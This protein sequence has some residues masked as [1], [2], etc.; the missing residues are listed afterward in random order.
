MLIDRWR[1]L[2][3]PPIEAE[4]LSWL[5][6]VW[7]DLKSSRITDVVG[8]YA[9]QT[10]RRDGF[11]LPSVESVE[12]L[13]RRWS[14]DE[15]GV[16][17][18]EMYLSP[19]S[20]Q[21][22]Y[23]DAEWKRIAMLTTLG[24]AIMMSPP[25]DIAHRVR[26]R[27]KRLL[28]D[29]KGSGERTGSSLRYSFA[30]RGPVGWS[31]HLVP[32]IPHLLEI[33]IDLPPTDSILSVTE[34]L[35]VGG[36]NAGPFDTRA[37][38][39][40][41][42]PLKSYEFFSRDMED[43]LP[44]MMQRLFEADRMPYERFREAVRHSPFILEQASSRINQYGGPSQF[45]DKVSP[46]FGDKVLEYCAVLG[47]DFVAHLSDDNSEAVK[48]F[49]DFR[50][51]D[52][53]LWAARHHAACQLKRLVFDGFGSRMGI[54]TAVIHLARSR[55]V[56]PPDP[57]ARKQLVAELRA[58]PAD[59]L[60][61]LLPV[62]RF[63]RRVLCEALGWESTLPL[64]QQIV[65]IAQIDEEKPSDWVFETRHST[66]PSLGSVDVAAVRDALAA[67]GEARS[68][69][70][71]T[72][73]HRAKMGAGTAV[74]LVEAA[75][76][77]NGKRIREQIVKRNQVA[78]KA[79]GLIPLEKGEDEV[80]ERY[81]CI[82][83]FASESKQF[84]AQ[85]QATEHAAAQAALENL[86]Q[87]AEYTDALRLEAAMEARAADTSASWTVDDYRINLEIDG[88]TAALAVRRGDTLLKSVPA[89][90][91]QDLAY[92]EMRDA[93]RGAREQASRFRLMFETVMTRGD[94]FGPNE[95]RALLRSPA[96]RAQL[97]SLILT[98]GGGFCLPHGD[99][100]LELLDGA[101]IPINGPVQVAHPL[102]L[103]EAGLLA[104]W[105]QEIVRRKLVQPFKQAFRELYLL[106]TAEI[107]TRT[108]SNRFAGHVLDS[109]VAARL[110]QARGWLL[111]TGDVVTPTKLFAR[112][113]LAAMFEIPDAGHYLS[114]TDTI[115]SDQVC[116]R[117]HPWSRAYVDD[118]NPFGRVPLGEI[119]PL[120]FSEAMRDADLVVSVAQ[121]DQD[122]LLSQEAYLR[123]GE[124]VRSVLDDLGLPGVTIDGHYAR[125]QGKLARYRVHL[126]SATIHIDPGNYLCIVPDRTARPDR[127]YL[128]FADEGDPKAREVL[129]K[130]ILLANDHLIKD[131]SILHQI[132][133]GGPL[134]PPV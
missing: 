94:A 131:Q 75:A 69:E 84:G 112:Q 17:A 35:V 67:A 114:E 37:F 53:L 20:W 99:S 3:L 117:P 120:V 96:A 123:R 64:I 102:H 89:A 13:R 124:L 27:L 100:S 41:G 133:A 47:R 59:S 79:Y 43:C 11:V 19:R 51:P 28:A 55:D 115:T 42:R 14:A 31:L 104:D 44:Q 2:R 26:D 122:G 52:K 56:E 61:H 32:G 62:A 68:R 15:L 16:M 85:K 4:M 7:S 81:L 72:M 12:R 23:R 87:N 127:L 126:A 119:P 134:E 83:Q 58:I 8:R 91:K 65:E 5:D 63:G 18:A 103:F 110:F 121:R 77:Y 10:H 80:R 97:C 57:E 130:V 93:V 1:R 54:D 48:Q 74:A 66:D 60:K 6:E 109:A 95:I 9:P 101:I 107:E 70:V 116:F 108:H 40:G 90:V 128:P 105:Q 129:S 21:P 46:H 34:E 29:P 33:L 92:G 76:G 45:H 88:A 118:A 49:V 73:F 30:Y 36:L 50:G 78:L 98:H 106:T 71:L 25:P 82:K 39:V 132:R 38:F 86:A 111:E 125:V 24:A 22:R 113:S